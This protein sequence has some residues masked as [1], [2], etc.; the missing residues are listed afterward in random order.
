MSTYSNVQLLIRL[1]QLLLQVMVGILNQFLEG[2][3]DIVSREA[4]NYFNVPAA[5]VKKDM[6]EQIY[7][8]SLGTL[9]D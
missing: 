8:C 2:D 9:V 3:Y 5:L 4:S 7:P 6:E 1:Y